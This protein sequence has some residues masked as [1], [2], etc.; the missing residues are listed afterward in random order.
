M[1]LWS[2]VVAGV[3]SCVARGG[4]LGA[5]TPAR[6]TMVASHLAPVARSVILRTRPQALQL[7]DCLR[8]ERV[9]ECQL[10]GHALISLPL[11]TF[12]D[13]QDRTEIAVSVNKHSKSCTV[14]MIRVSQPLITK[15]AV[16]DS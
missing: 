10:W 9:R 7:V 12:L 8:D 16:S 2:H 11:N 6:R 3:A 1:L 4:L 5:G 13:T 14:V 15:L